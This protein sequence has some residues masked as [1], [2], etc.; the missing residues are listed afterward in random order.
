M[1]MKKTAKL[2]H[3]PGRWTLTRPSH[4]LQGIEVCLWHKD[5]ISDVIR[6][7]IGGGPREVREEDMANAL[8]IRSAPE[9]LEAV[10]AFRDAV[11]PL[12]PRVKL[13]HEQTI[14]LD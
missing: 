1:K 4:P 12:S 6:V 7:G 11:G 10:I 9:L 3:T 8:L 2:L 5:A 14:A 13:T